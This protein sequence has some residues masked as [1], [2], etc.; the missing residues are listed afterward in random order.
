MMKRLNLLLAVLGVCILAGNAYAGTI[1]VWT[2]TAGNFSD[3][4]NWQNGGPSAWTNGGEIEFNTAATDATVNDG[5]W[6]FSSTMSFEFWG[7]ATMRIADGGNLKVRK[8]YLGTGGVGNIIQT[9][10]YLNVRGSDDCH[11]G[12]NGGEGNYTI[13][14]GTFDVKKLSL[15][16]ATGTLTVI[17]DA[18]TI[19]MNR[20]YLGSDR[21]GNYGTGTLEFQIGATGVSPLVIDAGGEFH[22]DEGGASSTVNLLLSATAAPAA[23]IVLINNGDNVTLVTTFDTLNGGSAA[24][25]TQIVLGGNT[26]SLSYVYAAGADAL[27]NDIALVYLGGASDQT[28]HTPVPANGA[29]VDTTLAL[30]DWINP[31]PNV[32]GNPVYCDVYLGMAA[33]RLSMDKITLGN[34][35]S[36]VDINTTNFPTY[37]NLQNNTQYYWAV[38]VHDGGNVRSGPMWSFLTAHNDAPVVNAGPDQV[39]WLGKSGTPSQEVIA[40]D[41]S[42]SDDGPYT[43]LWTQVA[44]GAPSVTITPNNVDDTSVTVT[45]RGTYV[46]MLTADDG[47]KQTSDT[48]QVIVGSTACDASHMSTGASYDAMDQNHDCVVN[49]ADFAMLIVSDWLTCTDR[50]TNCGN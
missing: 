38:D 20:L 35:I 50:L 9:G 10:G 4:T 21:S 2:G 5:P 30:L 3:G 29:S 26:Y 36:Q 42:S 11:I 49:M 40:L 16:G 43:V 37:G 1:D 6:D 7:G 47:A 14:G 48:V 15:S 44:N 25:G 45:A 31:D 33:D 28:A 34:D 27:A 18:A 17:G 39:S 41:G 32:P 19:M 22:F 24:E 23:D 8:L 46:F 13:S 12:H